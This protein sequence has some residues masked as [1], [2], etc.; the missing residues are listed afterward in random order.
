MSHKWAAPLTVLSVSALM[1]LSVSALGGTVISGASTATPRATTC[2][3]TEKSP[4][5]IAGGTYSSVTVDG[6]CFVN[7]GLVVVTGDV[8]V[9]TT[10]GALVAQFYYNDHNSPPSGRSG[11]TVDG[12]IVVQSGATLILGC[13]PPDN[14]C[15]EDPSPNDPTLDSPG[16]VDGSIIA[17][18]ALGVDVFDSVVK[19]DIREAG[20]GGGAFS[21]PGADCT[22]TGIFT[23]HDSPA[24]SDYEDNT[25]VGNLW[26]TGVQSCW[27][28][29]LRNQ[30]GGSVSYLNNTMA[31][32]DAMEVETNRIQGN[33]IC[34]GDSPAVQFGDAHGKP[35][36]VGGFATGQCG[37]GVLEPNPAPVPGPK[38]SAAG[39]KGSPAG[40]LQH[41]S[42]PTTT[43]QGYN[44]SATD[45][46]VFAFRTHFFGSAATSPSLTNYAGIATAPGG[47]GYW[48][49][50]ATGLVNGFG[51][52][53]RDFGSA[54]ANSPKP[55]VGIAAAPGGD[56][57]WEVAANGDVVN[58]GPAAGFFGSGD[59]LHLAKPIVGI[60]AAPT[61][62]GYYLVGSDGGVFAFG[63]GA[64]FQGSLGG[65]HLNKAIVGMVVDPSSGGYWLVA[66]DGGVF[67]FDAP[68]YGSLGAVHL[69]KP[70]VGIAAAPT[71]NGY[72]LVGS[73]GGVFAFGP[74]A[75]FQGSLGGTPL[76]SP[77]DGIA[78]G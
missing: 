2:T 23:L 41:L 55:T 68:F 12:N 74:G 27:L 52:N 66:A 14:A 63:L 10:N 3:G 37:F 31:D 28:G 24:Y 11:L 33:L 39:P 69:A 48:L 26:V 46:G 38:G 40:P 59:D 20:G 54:P 47:E 51:P 9:E 17:T 44:L 16:I 42:V 78:L 70:I 21:G 60:A 35:D 7:E 34:A 64:H 49:A 32:P 50:N 30:A 1:I 76:R 65:V 61:G 73:D 75:H 77:V 45:G 6:V 43:L 18:D 67:S 56:G 29:G 15:F 36:I 13:G 57:Y 4:R 62:N 53:G 58:F 8:T 19:G 72:Y 71:G 5:F 22:S 25:I